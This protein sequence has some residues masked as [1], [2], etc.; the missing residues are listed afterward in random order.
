MATH[1]SAQKDSLL[2]QYAYDLFCCDTG[3][4]SQS[5][6]LK[7]LERLSGRTL[8]HGQTPDR[9]ADVAFLTAGLSPTLRQNIAS[10]EQAAQG[11]NAFSIDRDEEW[12]KNSQNDLEEVVSRFPVSGQGLQVRLAVYDRLYDFEEKVHPAGQE[13]RFELLKKAVHDIRDNSDGMFDYRLNFMARRID[14]FLRK[15]PAKQRLNLITKIDEKTKDKKRYNYKP[16]INKLKNEAA[17]ERYRDREQV[18]ADNRVKYASADSKLPN[19][20]TPEEKIELYKE[21]LSLVDSQNWTR[22]RK[23]EQ[24]KKICTSLANLYQQT[25]QEEERKKICQYRT[26]C[27]NA[28][29]RTVEAARKKGYYN[30]R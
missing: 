14:Y 21:M 6:S 26:K 15:I 11:Y 27:D 9:S 28:Q 8:P 22:T 12:I 16:L 2:L 13:Y 18:R 4:N 19:A 3:K 25:G 7:D 30:G 29:Y 23:Y 20:H 1:F 24:K 5:N 17:T 10:L